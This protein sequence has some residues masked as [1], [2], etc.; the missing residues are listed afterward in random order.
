MFK[1]QCLALLVILSVF[2]ATVGAVPAD[3]TAEYGL[4]GFENKSVAKKLENAVVMRAY[5]NYA[6]VFG[7]R[8]NIDYGSEYIAPYKA[9]DTMYVP[10]SF[11]ITSFGGTSAEEDGTAETE[12][13]GKKMIFKEAEITEGFK[14][15]AQLYEKR[16]CVPA[17]ELAE[18]MSLE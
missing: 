18:A 14:S 10:L 9:D 5:N 13:N 1:K 6:Y 8:E 11:V 12:Y 2:A 4:Y 15:T 7:I 16:L 17:A 3:R